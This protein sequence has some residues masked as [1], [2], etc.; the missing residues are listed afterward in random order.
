MP[1]V[2]PF[3][4]APVETF[5]ITN[6]NKNKLQDER[7]PLRSGGE[8]RAECGMAGEKQ[9]QQET[10]G[11]RP[12]HLASDVEA[13][14]RSREAPRDPKA[15]TN[16]GIQV[17]PADIAERVNHGEHHEPEGQRD[18][19]MSN[20]AM[21]NIVNDNGTGAR[22]YQRERPDKLGDPFPHMPWDGG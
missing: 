4:F 15:D 3:S 11:E 22:K 21:G 9:P 19:D 8:S 14:S 17:R 6:I 12:G 1:A 5:K 10:R 20:R 2:I 16:R 18:S 13:D 7:L